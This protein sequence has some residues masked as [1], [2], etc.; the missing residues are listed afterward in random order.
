MHN[1]YCFLLGL[2]RGKKCILDCRICRHS[3]RS[4]W[5]DYQANQYV[6]PWALLDQDIHSHHS[7]AYDMAEKGYPSALD[8]KQ[9]NVD[10]FNPQCI[11]DLLILHR[12]LACTGVRSD[13]HVFY[14]AYICFYP[15]FSSL[16]RKR[17]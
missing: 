7:H 15:G 11:A 8:V 16:K 1:T 9:E 3:S 14:L 13:C 12:V 6:T 2:L 5:P 17:D 4:K 10:W